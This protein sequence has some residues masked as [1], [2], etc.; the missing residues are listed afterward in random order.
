MSYSAEV[1]A[2]SPVAYWRLGTGAT[3]VNDSS[4]GGA[5]PLT[6]TGTPTEV[7]GLLTG[8]AN[9]AR[10]L[11]G[12]STGRY[13]AA[14]HSAF[15]VVGTAAF[16]VEAW[17]NPTPVGSGGNLDASFR[18]FL[19][20][21]NAT[22]GWI[23]NCHSTS[24]FTFVRLAG[25]VQTDRPYVP[26]AIP[27]ATFHV[28][29]VYTG[30]VQRLYVNGVQRGTDLT[31]GAS[32]VANAQTVRT[33]PAVGGTAYLACTLDECAFYTT[34]LSGARILAHYN[35]GIGVGGQEILPDA[36]NATA[37]WTTAPLFSKVN[38]ASDATIITAT[39]A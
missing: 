33:G 10:L 3:D 36:D 21:S 37:G 29:G 19:S 8:D 26:A 11:P 30:V 5:H 28:V 16:T 17:V 24:G 32:V 4:A 20:H 12:A 18:S 14:D 35:A 1:L 9:T 7:S 13:D 39:A 27:G 15:D 2:D 31:A 34:A 25:G 22:D 38:D 23:L 6:K